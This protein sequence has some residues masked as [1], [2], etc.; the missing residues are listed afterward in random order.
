MRGQSPG[1]SDSADSPHIT[2]SVDRRAFN[3]RERSAR[4]GITWRRVAWRTGH[5]EDA[6][7]DADV[8]ACEHHLLLVVAAA[9]FD[10]IARPEAHQE[11]EYVERDDRGQPHP[12]H[13]RL[14]EPLGQP[15]RRLCRRRRRRRSCCFGHRMSAVR[16]GGGGRRNGSCVRRTRI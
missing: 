8:A 15:P 16:R 11:D 13:I 4:D 5:R 14:L 1:R 2:L 10:L 9:R 3:A 6:D 12:I 7:E